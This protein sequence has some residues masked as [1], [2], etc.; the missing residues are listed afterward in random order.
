M[1]RNP[2]R[3]QLLLG[4]AG[5]I[6]GTAGCLSSPDDE[7]PVNGTP[8][9]EIPTGT[10]SEPPALEDAE[11]HDVYQQTIDS[12]ALVQAIGST[13]YVGQGSGFVYADGIVLTN[14]HVVS[15]APIAELQFPDNQWA[16]G[17]IIGTDRY[18]DL[19]VIQSSNLPAS[20]T[21]IPPAPTRATIG[22]EVITLGNPFG[23]EES[24]SQGIVSGRNRSLPSGTNFR[25]PATIQT[26][27]SV[28]PGNSGGPLVDMDGRFLGVI[29]ARA[30]QDIGFA[31][32]W[33]LVERVAPALIETGAYEHVYLGIRLAQVNPLIAEVNN[34]GRP[35]GVLVTSVV[36]EGPSAGVLRGTSTSTVRRGEEVPVGGD[37]IVA[38]DGVGIETTEQLSTY[39][40]LEKSPGDDIEVTI[41]RDGTTQNVTVT[42]EARPS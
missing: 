5:G 32:S 19:A 13:G 40:A 10:P 4:I 38:L 11:Y 2:S 18:S 22:Q 33:R 25:I 42:L 17:T 28:N 8:I 31:V 16:E 23:L 20:A 21:P 14:Q 12:V 37:V 27:A 35:T 15:D 29:T 36:P 34:L 6:A 41:I 7:A 26:D 3:R 24:I 39:L 1:V 30:G 9:D